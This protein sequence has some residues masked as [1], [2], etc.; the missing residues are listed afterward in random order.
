MFAEPEQA[1]PVLPNMPDGYRMQRRAMSRG[2]SRTTDAY[3][4]WAPGLP[5][6]LSRGE[7][8]TRRTGVQVAGSGGA[9]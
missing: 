4:H 7:A 9:E 1:T 3:V 2:V 8:F 6:F 5:F